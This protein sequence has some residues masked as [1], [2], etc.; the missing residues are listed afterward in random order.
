MT[1]CSPKVSCNTRDG[2]HSVVQRLTTNVV[3]MTGYSPKVKHNIRG[4]WHST[5][6]GLTANAAG[7]MGPNIE[8]NIRGEWHSVVQGLCQVGSPDVLCKLWT[9]RILTGL[10]VVGSY[11]RPSGLMGQ[12]YS[13]V[14][15]WQTQCLHSISTSCFGTRQDKE[16]G[17]AGGSGLE[18]G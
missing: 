18:E 1:G 10:F 5:V 11:L 14:L 4:G 9:S 12:V 7:M 3:E 17:D 16:F 6:Q 2:W 15:R 13:L 8:C